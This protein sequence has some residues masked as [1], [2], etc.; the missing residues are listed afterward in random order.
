MFLR[1]DTDRS[2]SDYLNGPF[3]D[4][5]DAWLGQLKAGNDLD[6]DDLVGRLVKLVKIDPPYLGEPALRS[7]CRGQPRPAEHEEFGAIFHPTTRYQVAIPISGQLQLLDYWPNEIDGLVPIDDDYPSSA[8]LDV[9]S[10]NTGGLDERIA[11]LDHFLVL[12]RWGKSTNPPALVTFVD[13]TED[14]ERRVHVGDLDPMKVV[15]GYISAIAPIVDGVGEQCRRFLADELPTKARHAVRQRVERIVSRESVRNNL[16]FPASWRGTRPQI[17]ST[18]RPGPETSSR[19]AGE[20]ELVHRD[21]L[22]A[23]SFD[24]I[25]IV[26]RLW[27]D[28]VERYPAA[29]SVLKEDRL[30]DLLATTLNACLPGANREV[31]SRGGKSDIFIRA[32]VLAEGRSPAKIFV[33]E[34]KWWDGAKNGAGEHLGQLLGYMT[35]VDTAAI[36]LFYVDNATV[37]GLASKLVN[38]IQER[39]DFLGMRESVVSGWPIVTMRRQGDS[40]AEVLLA[41]IHLPRP[42]LTHEGD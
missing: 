26:V 6:E 32:D 40:R 14:D 11:A 35:T 42:V 25:Q 17:E 10:M 38:A 22:A 39:D 4:P 18:M 15:E 5:H 2:L 19:L 7:E 29:F 21:R 34:A 41:F 30:S 8:E 3:L 1:H 37:D 12:R 16:G 9:R 36:L 20:V 23:T 31:Y 13:L 28:G 24:E 33:L 27:A